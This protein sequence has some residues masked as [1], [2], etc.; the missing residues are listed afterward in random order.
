MS[1][2][3]N[4]TTPKKR[5]LSNTKQEQGDEEQR[6]TSEKIVQTTLLIEASLLY[7]VKGIALKRKQAG[8]KPDTVTGIIKDA[9]T[10]I[11]KNER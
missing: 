3:M 5:R 7:A 10:E 8:I 6:P 9:L 11:V 1:K 4:S 2:K